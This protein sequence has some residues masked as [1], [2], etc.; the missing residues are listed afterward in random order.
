MGAFV[1]QS[2]R[3]LETLRAAQSARDGGWPHHLHEPDATLSIVATAHAI[4]LLRFFGYHYASDEVQHG[5][6]YLSTQV[7]KHLRAGRRGPYNRYAAYA[8]WGLTRYQEAAADRT[9]NGAFDYCI[10]WL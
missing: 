5:L 6:G 3:F 4:D 2:G 1:E 8:L 9:W 10:T 7:H